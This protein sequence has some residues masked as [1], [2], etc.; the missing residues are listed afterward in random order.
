M[1]QALWSMSSIENFLLGTPRS[2]N[3]GKKGLGG[4]S[5]KDEIWNDGVYMRDLHH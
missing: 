1:F 4:A 2:G 5:K 3:V